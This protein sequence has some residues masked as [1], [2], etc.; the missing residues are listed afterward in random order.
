MVKLRGIIIEKNSAYIYQLYDTSDC[1]K[2]Q[3]SSCSL[4][5]FLVVEN[6]K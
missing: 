2:S 6:L 5:Y 1:L 3:L 4:T